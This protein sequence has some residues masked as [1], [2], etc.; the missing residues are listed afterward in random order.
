MNKLNQI[1]LFTKN[2]I[3]ILGTIVILSIATTS[4]AF[5]G[6][7]LQH[8]S[9]NQQITKVVTK[10][11]SKPTPITPTQIASPTSLPP[12]FTPTPATPSLFTVMIGVYDFSKGRTTDRI[13]HMPVKLYKSDGTFIGEKIPNEYTRNGPVGTGGNAEFQIPYGS[14]KAVAEGDAKKGD[15]SFT[16]DS[17]SDDI[18]YTIYLKAS[19]IKIT[20]KYF[21]DSNK[22]T[23]YDQGETTFADKKVYAIVDTEGKLYTA[24]ETKTDG[25]GYF[26]MYPGIFGKYLITGEQVNSYKASPENWIEL[27]GA[28][29]VE[30]NVYVWE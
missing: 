26:E 3:Y 11:T 30:R 23:Q 18:G 13:L 22:N 7:N 27:S 1:T 15:V 8:K 17:A 14:Y 12:T 10:V 28:R 5:Y 4:Y 2:H 21:L 29:T 20:G 16:I 19:A 25:N 9:E 24:F 6:S